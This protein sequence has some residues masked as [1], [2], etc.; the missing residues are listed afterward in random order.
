MDG[1]F[2]ARMIEKTLEGLQ[3]PYP[4]DATMDPGTMNG[5]MDQDDA[6]I[7]CDEYIKVSYFL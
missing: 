3:G 2:Q 6:D 5:D 4:T 7:I 1:E